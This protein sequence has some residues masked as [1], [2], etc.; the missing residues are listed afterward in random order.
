[1]RVLSGRIEAFGDCSAE[2]TDGDQCFAGP[3]AVSME[4]YLEALFCG[5]LFRRHFATG[6]SDQ[7]QTRQKLE[8]VV[9]LCANLAGGKEYQNLWA[10]I[11]GLG[12]ARIA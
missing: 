2:I 1:M 10:R 5:T 11:L 7:P 12:P 9:Q 6:F 8:P 3:L 4:A